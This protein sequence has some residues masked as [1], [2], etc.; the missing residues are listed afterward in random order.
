MNNFNKG[1]S[2]LG[3]LIV[4]ILVVLALSYFK[5]SVKTIIE[6]PEGQGNISYVKETSKTLGKALWDNYLQDP[7]KKL[8]NTI[9][10]EI[11]KVDWKKFFLD[12]FSKKDYGSMAPVVEFSNTN[13]QVQTNN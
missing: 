2:I 5:I 4:G 13:Q 6:S 10:A 12:I 1:I 3:I 9:Y 7:V 8:E 11:K